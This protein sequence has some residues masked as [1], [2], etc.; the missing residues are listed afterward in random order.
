MT[1]RRCAVVA[2]VVSFLALTL[3]LGAARSQRPERKYV[4]RTAEKMPVVVESVRNLQ[5]DDEEWFRDLE[6][7]VKN[8]ADKPVYFVKVVL[9]FPDIPAPPAHARADGHAP[10]KV[11]T[12]FS[13][14]YGSRRLGNI[15][16]LAGPEDESLKPGETH[17]FKMPESRVAGLRNM[18][19]TRGLQAGAAD[20]IEIEVNTIS[21]GDGTGY[22]GN[23]KYVFPKESNERGGWRGAARTPAMAAANYPPGVN[24]CGGG[25][26]RA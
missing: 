1:S 4:D 6:V 7:V 15:K 9:T 12:G 26:A 3:S 18:K 8:N 16:N 25:P 2:A 17:A 14:S 13:L 24:A 22:V 21:F 11:M 23:H 10:S 19:L 5:K 20:L